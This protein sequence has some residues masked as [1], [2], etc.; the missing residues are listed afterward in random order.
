M[1]TSYIPEETFAVCTYQLSPSPQKFIASREKVSVFS[2]GKPLLTTADKNL[3]EPFVCKSPVNIAASLLAFGAGIL[4]GALLVSNP[5]GW[6]VAGCLV[7]AAGAAYAV[8]AV[9][10]KCTSPMKSGNWMMYKSTVRFNGH[11]AIT[12]VSLLKCGSGGVLKAF[13]DEQTACSAAKTIMKNNLAEVGVNVV[14]SFFAGYLA[15]AGFAQLFTRFGIGKG[16]A[17]FGATNIA[18]LGITWSLQ[19]GQRE[20]MRSDDNLSDNEI[21]QNMNETIDENSWV[22]DFNKPSDLN[23]LASLESFADAANNGEV[24][25]DNYKLKQDLTR[26]SELSDYKLR[27]SELAKQ[28]FAD[29]NDGKYGEATKA[30]IKSKYAR[31]IGNNSNNV[32]KGINVASKRFKSNAYNM[33][34]SGG[35]GALF[36]LPFVSTYFTENARKS[37][38]E[39]AI[40]DINS[41]NGKGI[42]VTTENPL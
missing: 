24:V 29:L 22:G 17:V 28:I 30:E 40:K 8:V 21:Y 26:L 36:F 19:Y 9:S 2:N 20:Y 15:P 25:I 18:G 3:Q 13:F 34:K 10:H 33:I 39:E 12:E 37:F 23:D 31:W 11:N 16:L 6:I 32:T 42:N 14:V 41:N 38:A 27:K 35:Q 1:N 5:I 7:V 4:V